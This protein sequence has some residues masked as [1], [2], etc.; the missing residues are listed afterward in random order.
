MTN[1]E[2][3]KFAWNKLIKVNNNLKNMQLF[4]NS[5]NTD[6]FTATLNDTF[7]IKFNGTDFSDPKDVKTDFWFCKKIIPYGNFKSPIK[8]HA[9]FIESYKSIREELHKRFKESKKDKVFITGHSLGGALTTL[10]AVDFE[11]NFNAKLEAVAFGSPRVGNKAFFK[12]FSKRL[13]C[14]LN[15]HN[16]QDLV[17]KLSPFW[18]FFKHVNQ[19]ISI[20]KKRWYLFLGSIIDHFLEE[21]DRNI[22]NL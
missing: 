12:S 7:I 19:K 21:Y 10:A 6:G 11:Y 18:T 9:G 14:F 3:I 1:N 4:T 2:K 13:P 15:V 16:G 20:G 8:V 22:N 5:A 17:A